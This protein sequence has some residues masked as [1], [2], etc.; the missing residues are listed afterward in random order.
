MHALLG[1]M[2]LMHACCKALLPNHLAQ[3]TIENLCIKTIVVPMSKQYL[4]IP[5]C[6]QYL[7]IPM[8]K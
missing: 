2:K 3:V 6:K 1:C 5:M 4:Q 7:Q 8:C